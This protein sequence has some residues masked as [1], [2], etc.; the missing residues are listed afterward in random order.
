MT[1][2]FMVGILIAIGVIFV[3]LS[4]YSIIKYYVVKKRNEASERANE[5]IFLAR[6]QAQQREKTG[7]VNRGIIEY[8]KEHKLSDFSKKKLPPENADEESKPEEEKVP[9]PI[10]PDPNA[11]REPKLGDFY[12]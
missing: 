12:K 5:M 4:S 2:N 1:K 7:E 10:V 9:W 6:I 11:P 8:E 3:A